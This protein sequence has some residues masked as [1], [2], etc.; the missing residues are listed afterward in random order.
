LSIAGT[1]RDPPRDLQRDVAVTARLEGLN[2]AWHRGGEERGQPAAPAASIRIQVWREP[3]KSS[4]FLPRSVIVLALP[5]CWCWC[6]AVRFGGFGAPVAILSSA[7]LSTSGVF[8]ALLVTKT[9]L[10][11][12]PLSWPDH[13]DRI[14]A[15]TRILRSDADQQFAPRCVGGTA[16]IEAGERRLRPIVMTALATVA[17]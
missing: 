7:L 12:S 16:M 8:L 9:T 10:Q 15:R 4:R 13:G 3:T 11:T 2:L 6:T 17:V 1:D 14:V 5:S